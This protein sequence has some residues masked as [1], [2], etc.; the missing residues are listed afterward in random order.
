ML[1]LPKDADD[2][3]QDALVSV[4]CALR[5]ED[6]R[7][8]SSVR[9]YA[10]TVLRNKAFDHRKSSWTRIFGRAS[11]PEDDATPPPP[12]STPRWKDP[13]AEKVAEALM[14]RLQPRDRVVVSLVRAGVSYAEIGTQ[15]GI[16]EKNAQKIKERAVE[17]LR[18]WANEEDEGA[19]ASSPGG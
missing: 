4:V 14:A 16:T 13:D 17:R 9:G 11:D 8:T 6:G 2:V 3:Y 7:I 1:V 15:L 10:F 12:P 18:G 5:V 19:P